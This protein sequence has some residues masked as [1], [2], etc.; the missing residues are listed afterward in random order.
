MSVTIHLADDVDVSRGDMMCRPNNQPTVGQDLDAMMC[1]MS[2]KPLRRTGRYALKHTT[3]WTRAVVTEL[4][5]RL[6]VNTGAPRSRA[7][8]Q[9][10]AQRPRPDPAAHDDADRVRP[11]PQQPHDRLVHPRRRGDERDGRAPAC[12]SAAEAC[13]E[14]A[15]CGAAERGRLARSL[16]LSPGPA[17]A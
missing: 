7:P 3:R 11:V 12:Y 5:Y 16:G 4:L 17:A 6:D 15:P 8:T 13:A 10:G 9:L 1:W 14:G 2:D